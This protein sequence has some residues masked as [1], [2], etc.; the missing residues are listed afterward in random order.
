MKPT[1]SGQNSGDLARERLEHAR[2]VVRVEA[3]AI[4]RLEDGLGPAFLDAVQQVLDCQGQVIVTGMGKAGLVG[5]KLSATLAST[6][7][8]SI[9]LHPRSWKSQA[10]RVSRSPT[11]MK[12]CRF[13]RSNCRRC[14]ASLRPHA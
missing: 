12:G 10:V 6:G 2:E 9:S 14:S 7:T 8:P 4:A 1:E 11:M 13:W 5:A 3:R